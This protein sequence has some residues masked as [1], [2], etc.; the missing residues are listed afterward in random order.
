MRRHNVQLDFTNDTVTFSPAHCTKYLSCGEEDSIRRLHQ[1]PA[2]VPSDEVEIN[3]ISV[4]TVPIEE[5]AE[6]LQDPDTEQVAVL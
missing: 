2:S 4:G 6:L 1:L 5:F 3:G